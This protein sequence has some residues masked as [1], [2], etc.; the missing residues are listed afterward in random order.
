MITGVGAIG[1]AGL[2]GCVGV[3]PGSDDNGH[4]RTTETSTAGSTRKTSTPVTIDESAQSP[5]TFSTSFESSSL[6]PTVVDTSESDAPAYELTTEH[7]ATGDRSVLLSST[8]GTTTKARVSTREPVT[9]PAKVKTR[10]KLV[11]RDGGQNAI[12]LLVTHA[13]TKA[14]TKI[15]IQN[16][17]VTA[18]GTNSSGSKVDFE[19]SIANT[20]LGDTWHDLTI[21]MRSDEMIAM[22]DRAEASIPIPTPMAGTRVYPALGVNSWGG[23]DA[24]TVAFDDFRVSKL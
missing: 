2:T 14:N 24:I 9:L 13:R 20:R 15:Y 21:E 7:A 3:L 4:Q 23:G 8:P 10:V 12:N 19:R 6:P 16:G 1:A 17:R 22:F 5:A 11:A 18:R